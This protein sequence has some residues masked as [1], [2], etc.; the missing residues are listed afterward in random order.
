M[1]TDT[2]ALEVAAGLEIEQIARIIAPSEWAERD[3]C[4]QLRDYYDQ[5]YANIQLFGSF[6]G[7]VDRMTGPSLKAADAILSALAAHPVEI[8]AGQPKP[9]DAIMVALAGQFLALRGLTQAYSDW[10]A[11]GGEVALSR[12]TSEIEAALKAWKRWEGELF[13][14]PKPVT[15]GSGFCVRDDFYDQYVELQIMREGALASLRGART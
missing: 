6:E 11:S 7:W 12:D 14:A 13:A 3:R 10:L 1:T 8:E 15:D 4:S 2:E 5:E 9:N